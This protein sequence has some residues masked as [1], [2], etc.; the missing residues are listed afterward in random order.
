MNGSTY[1]PAIWT[2]LMLAAALLLSPFTGFAQDAKPVHPL[3]ALSGAEL[4]QVKAVLKAEGKIGPQ[5]RFHSVD[6]D[7]PDKAAVLTWRPGSMLPRRAIAV[8][9]EAGAVHE[10]AIDLAAGR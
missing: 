8:V 1:R 6:L 9:S 2:Q 4:I 3:D 10:A 7:E 5:A